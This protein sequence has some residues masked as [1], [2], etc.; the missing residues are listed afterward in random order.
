MKKNAVAAAT[1][2]QNPDRAAVPRLNATR[3][4]LRRVRAATKVA[5]ANDKRF[6]LSKK[7]GFRALLFC[8]IQFFNCCLR[9]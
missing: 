8:Y 1:K 6:H 9:V 7:E 5:K 3:I 2:A 4:V